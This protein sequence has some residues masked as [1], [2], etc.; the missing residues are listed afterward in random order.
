MR[1]RIALFA[2]AIISAGAFGLFISDP[3]YAEPATEIQPGLL[4]TSASYAVGFAARYDGGGRIQGGDAWRGD[5]SWSGRNGWRRPYRGFY[6]GGY[7]EP[8]Y[9]SPYYAGP[10]YSEPDYVAPYYGEQNYVAPKCDNAVV[11]PYSGGWVCM[12]E[13]SLP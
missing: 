9:M 10:Y 6:G 1:T 5:K 13:P 2:V 12:I 8:E 3:I 11:D 7:I 4:A